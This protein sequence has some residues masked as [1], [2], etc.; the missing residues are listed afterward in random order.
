MKKFL[1]V[2]IQYTILMTLIS[3]SNAQPSNGI[4][5]NI[6]ASAF[7][8]LIEN[9]EGVLLDVRTPDEVNKGKIMGAINIDFYSEDFEEKIAGLDKSKPVYIYCASGGRSVNTM[10]KMNKLGFIKVY[11]LHGGIGDWLRAGYPISK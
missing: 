6:S 10:N 5:K 9:E 4:T 1:K 11:N 7:K 2:L 3:C 8:T